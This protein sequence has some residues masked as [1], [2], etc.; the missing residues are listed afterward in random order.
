MSGIID[1]PMEGE[2]EKA[3]VL[4]KTNVDKLIRQWMMEKNFDMNQIADFIQ[5]A[6]DEHVKVLNE[7]T[8]LKNTAGVKTLNF[9]EW[10]S[11]E[12]DYR[13]RLESAKNEKKNLQKN[14]NDL[15]A[16]HK[17]C[18]EDLVACEERI[19]TTEAKMTAHDE[20]KKSLKSLQK[21]L[22]DEKEMVERLRREKTEGKLKRVKFYGYLV[23][24][25]T[26]IH[27]FLMIRTEPDASWNELS[28][29]Y[30]LHL[31][32]K[33]EKMLKQVYLKFKV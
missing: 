4:S 16:E 28:D 29:D 12:L 33:V 15:K 32:Q 1:H 23:R 27:G 25:L 18:L 6:Y 2:D 17:K 5:G 30:E 8:H 24:I 31:L 7:N 21:L 9:D 11:T 14:F 20:L 10:T 22:H 26:A 13:E 19:A 3:S